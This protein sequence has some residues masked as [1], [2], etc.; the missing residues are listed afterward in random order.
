MIATLA[1]DATVGTGQRVA[2]AA[3]LVVD[4]RQA[5]E[6]A[7]RRGGGH[8]ASALAV[9]QSR[10]EPGLDL[11]E[12]A[13]HRRAVDAEV[14]PRRGEAAGAVQRQHDAV[15]VPVVVAPGSAHRDMR[16]ACTSAVCR[17]AMSCVMERAG[18]REDPR[19]MS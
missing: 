19:T 1:L 9:E 8:R 18:A 6:H 10:A 4:A 7:E 15:V 11:G 2:H 14:A 17:K 13:R 5:L 3:Q 16:A 12:P